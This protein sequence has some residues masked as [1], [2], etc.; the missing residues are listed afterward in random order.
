[1]SFKVVLN[2]GISRRCHGFDSSFSNSDFCEINYEA[3]NDRYQ[4]LQPLVTRD[5]YFNALKGYVPAIPDSLD[6]EEPPRPAFPLRK[7]MEVAERLYANI[8]DRNR[9]EKKRR[10]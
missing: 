10:T 4:N 3:V 5:A 7:V 9:A 8:V 1:L 2:Q 6:L